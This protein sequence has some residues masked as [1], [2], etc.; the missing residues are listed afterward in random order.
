MVAYERI[1]TTVA[2]GWVLLEG[3]VDRAHQRDK[4]S[5]Q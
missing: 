4:P 3:Q 2:D 5:V 1:R